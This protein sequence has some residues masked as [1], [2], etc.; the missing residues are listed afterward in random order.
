M[1]LGAMVVRSNFPLNQ[2]MEIQN[3]HHFCVQIVDAFLCHRL[4]FM[5]VKL[6]NFVSEWTCLQKCIEHI[7]K[8]CVQ[9][10]KVVHL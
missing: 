5:C 7:Q 3:L 1:G 2:F 8:Q 6:S 4:L 9:K 10:L